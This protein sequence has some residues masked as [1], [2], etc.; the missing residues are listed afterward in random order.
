MSFTDIDPTTMSCD[1]SDN[2]KISRV[3]HATDSNGE[4]QHQRVVIEDA[5]N[6]S[7]VDFPANCTIL[8]RDLEKT[9]YK[10]FDI[11]VFG[12]TML[13]CSH[14]FD[15][16]GRTTGFVLWMN[17]KGL[18]VD[19]PPDSSEILERMGIPP[20]SIDALL[21]TH[22]HADHDAG[23]FQ[24]ILHAEK[25]KIYTTETIM[26]SFLRK[27]S[28]LTGFDPVFLSKMFEFHPLKVGEMTEIS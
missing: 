21:V 16:K 18:M 25:I 11:P 28:A 13:G 7:Q 20:S 10:P 9:E 26:G 6:N 19:P 3:S 2:V 17:R 5:E 22:C 12:V 24:K 8:K 4:S 15:K 23:T 14:G 27:Y 1:F